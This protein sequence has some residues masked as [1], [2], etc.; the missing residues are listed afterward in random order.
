MKYLDLTLASIPANLALDE[1][2]LDM[3]D[4][5]G[6]VLRIWQPNSPAAILGRASRVAEEIERTQCEPR[7]VPAFRRC[8]GGATVLIGPGCLMYA[9]VLR[10]CE[11]PELQVIDQAHQ[12][13]LIRM[14]DALRAAE[15]DVDVSGTS[16]LTIGGR[17]FSGNS[18][19]C[20]QHALLYHGTLLYDADLDLIASCLKMPPRKP[21]YRG[22]RSH[23]DFLTNLPVDPARLRQGIRH[24]WRA[25]E[26]LDAL[27][28]AH[29]VE[30]VPG[31]LLER[32]EQPGWNFA[33]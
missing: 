1:A 6:D 29:L 24:A 11:R 4:Q 10:T 9:V 28:I 15:C 22:E 25:E 23:R 13:V 3:A 32:Y 19:R 30:R 12:Y 2:L 18:L 5:I 8:S 7:G 27:S 33:R 16:D 31:Y 14:R 26:D 21:D 20:K 17:K